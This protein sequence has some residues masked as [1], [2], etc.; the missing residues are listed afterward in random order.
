VDRAAKLQV[1]RAAKLQVDRA[2]KRSPPTVDQM[3]GVAI[4]AKPAWNR[5]RAQRERIDGQ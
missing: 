4:G 1:D 5:H 3:N 2:A